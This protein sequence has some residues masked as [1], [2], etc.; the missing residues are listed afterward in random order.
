MSFPVEQ[1][2]LTVGVLVAA[3]ITGSF[4]VYNTKLNKRG[5]K[6]E[7][8]KEKNHTLTVAND[9]LEQIVP[10]LERKDEA[11]DRIADVLENV[12]EIQRLQNQRIKQVEELAKQKCQAPE[13]I[14]AVNKLIEVCERKGVQED[15]IK[16][17]TENY[18]NTEES[19]GN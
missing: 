2:I 16:T 11:L 5:D 4:A 6:V 3:V 14:V 13:L 18:E 8:K 15:L 10:T 17:L 19:T 7:E 9:V 1:I 12:L